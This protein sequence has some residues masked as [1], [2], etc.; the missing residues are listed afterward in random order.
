MHRLQKNPVTAAVGLQT[1][2][3]DKKVCYGFPLLQQ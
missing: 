2:D 3:I 1:F